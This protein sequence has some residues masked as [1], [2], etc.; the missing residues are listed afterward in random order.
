VHLEPVAKKSPLTLHR[1][2]LPSAFGM[3][4]SFI[5]PSFSSETFATLKCFV[6]AIGLE[7]KRRLM[8][9]RLE[10]LRLGKRGRSKVGDGGGIQ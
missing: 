6:I 2:T 3:S 8:G 9:M 5:C 7:E 4:T 1:R 10:R